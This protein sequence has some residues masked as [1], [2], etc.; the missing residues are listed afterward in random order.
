ML[1]LC[2]KPVLSLLALFI[3]AECC[4]TETRPLILIIDPGTH[5]RCSW[6]PG[7]PVGAQA[8]AFVTRLPRAL[9]DRLSKC[10]R[11]ELRT[12]FSEL[13]RL[14]DQLDAGDRN[15]FISDMQGLVPYRPDAF[16]FTSIDKG[17]DKIE[18]RAE[19][20]D[21][22]SRP[23]AIVTERI[24]FRDFLND[25]FV[26]QVIQV[27]AD[28]LCG[29][30]PDSGS[31]GFWD[32]VG[33]GL[34][35]SYRGGGDRVTLGNISPEVRYIPPHP[36]D[37][38][39]R[40]DEI[41]DPNDPDNYLIGANSAQIE[42]GDRQAVELHLDLW[43]IVGIGLRSTAIAGSGRV[44]DGNLLR[45]AYIPAKEGEPYTG[46]AFIYYCLKVKERGFFAEGSFSVP[47]SFGWPVLSRGG[48]RRTTL[49]VLGGSNFLLPEKVLVE[50]EQGWDRFGA[51][52]IQ[53]SSDVGEL[54]FTDWYGGLEVVAQLSA[55]L[56]FDARFTL[57]LTEYSGTFTDELTLAVERSWHPA[58]NV[59]LTLMLS[60]RSIG[61]TNSR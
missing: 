41:L 59:G 13:L 37:L 11:F 33:V 23:L 7:D 52:Q 36:E 8:D 17:N 50:A 21:L 12:Q 35:F 1:K 22:S 56:R 9:Y 31:S 6:S 15:E 57:T 26:F 18:L 45:Q 61:E 19:I 53:Q 49:R 60:G 51:Y 32:K 46:S 4:A 55:R 10:D 5:I 14:K 40:G 48:K 34:G 54:E 29:E 47:I 20:L 27:M 28:S 58:F 43:G 42:L 30:P 3:F 44:V 38:E 24:E 25:D 39:Q 16:L 2:L